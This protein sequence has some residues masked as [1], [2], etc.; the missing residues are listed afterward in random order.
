MIENTFVIVVVAYRHLSTLIDSVVV[1]VGATTTTATA[2][3]VCRL[4][5]TWTYV[6]C[7]SNVVVHWLTEPCTARY[8]HCI[9][10]FVRHTMQ[11]DRSSH[12]SLSTLN[13]TF[14]SGAF[15]PSLSPFSPFFPRVSKWPLKST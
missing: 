11:V 9:S 15:F 1:V 12:Q 6:C 4:R 10:E 3:V 5:C 14:I 7:R 8:S 2:V 13:Q